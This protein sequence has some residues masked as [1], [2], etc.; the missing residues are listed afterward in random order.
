MAGI[1]LN[2]RVFVSG[3]IHMPLVL[4]ISFNVGGCGR[5]QKHCYSDI[6]IFD[7]TTKNWWNN[8]YILSD[9]RIGHTMSVLPEIDDIYP[10]CV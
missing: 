9:S 1:S 7:P 4:S 8:E 10:F 6:L 3:T 2:N 5:D